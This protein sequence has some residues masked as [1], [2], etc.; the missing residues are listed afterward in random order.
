MFYTC[1]SVILFTGGVFASVHDGIH[2]PP[3]A[4]IPWESDTPWEADTPG[5]HTP[6]QEADTPLGSRHPPQA[7]TPL[8]ADPLTPAQCILGDTGNKQA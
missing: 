1:L 2:T 8:E 4:D 7:D 5:K 6:P 3:A